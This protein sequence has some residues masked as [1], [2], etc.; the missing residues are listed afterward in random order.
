MLI[1]FNKTAGS[2]LSNQNAVKK[3]V[4]LRKDYLI[5]QHN[6][7]NLNKEVYI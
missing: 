1:Q 2:I 5:S 7:Q 3:P 4:A 6:W